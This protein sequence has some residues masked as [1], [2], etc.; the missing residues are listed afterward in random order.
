MKT[1][2]RFL[3]SA[4]ANLCASFLQNAGI[5]ATVFEDSSLGDSIGAFKNAIRVV[6]PDDQFEKAEEVLKTYEKGDDVEG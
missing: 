1:I 6:V 5:D 2:E 3:T 4:E